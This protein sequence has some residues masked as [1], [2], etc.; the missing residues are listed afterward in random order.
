MGELH[1]RG[2]VRL[3]RS[4]ALPR[5]GRGRWENR[6]PEGIPA[7]REPSPPEGWEGPVGESHSR[8]VTGS[9]SG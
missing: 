9:A 4:L 6:I 1:S 3:G 5:V 8:G 7:R 2:G